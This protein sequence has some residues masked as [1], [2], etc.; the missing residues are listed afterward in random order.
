MT[1]NIY[2]EAKRIWREDFAPLLER[3]E[4]TVKYLPPEGDALLITLYV[5]SCEIYYQHYYIA[6]LDFQT[7]DF[8]RVKIVEYFTGFPGLHVEKKF[9]PAKSF[10]REFRRFLLRTITM[11]VS[12]ISRHILPPDA[13][14]TIKDTT[15]ISF[16]PTLLMKPSHNTPRVQVVPILLPNSF[17]FGVK[18]FPEG[19]PLLRVQYPLSE[20]PI[21]AFCNLRESLARGLPLQNFV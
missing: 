7:Y 1:E 11:T 6:T 15:I 16:R 5:K 12:R 19:E 18:T 21:Q 4:F 3:W 13:H 14:V 10:P 20:N 8:Q 2:E 9:P 17:G